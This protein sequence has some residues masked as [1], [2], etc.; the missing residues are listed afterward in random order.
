MN[1]HGFQPKLRA[2]RVLRRKD[3]CWMEYVQC[4]STGSEAAARRFYERMGGI[5]A[6]AHLLRAV[7]CHR[8]NLIASGEHPVLVDVDALWHVSPLTRTESSAELLFRTGFFPNAN[9]GSLQSRSSA[10]APAPTGTHVAR[11]AGRPLKPG[12]YRRD[13][14][15]GFAKAWHC[16]LAT[17]K[18]R[19]AFARQLRRIR[20]TER[21]WM[22]WATET[23]AAISHA[24]VQPPAL[25]LGRERELLI[26][27]R[28]TRETVSPVVVEAEIR[29][30]RQLDIPY[31]VGRSKQ[32][33]P[34]DGGTVP[35]ELIKALYA[36][37]LG[38]R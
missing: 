24:S 12:R 9:P 37:L 33:L 31:F 26:R 17:R 3:Y 13:L 20:S 21:R 8:D 25:R 38:P 14:A 22:Y 28:C 16:I 23:Y 1:R 10:L 32:S 2:A 19:Q 6:A 27:Q 7:D 36:A 35:P 34:L 15:R 5:I 18:A 11:L 4:A 29:A 30:L